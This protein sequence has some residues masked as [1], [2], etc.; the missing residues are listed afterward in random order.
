MK[1]YT[2]THT[3]NKFRHALLSDAT[4]MPPTFS[5]IWGLGTSSN[6]PPHPLTKIW[7]SSLCPCQGNLR[8][9]GTFVLHLQI[10][11]VR[12]EL[13]NGQLSSFAICI[14]WHVKSS[15]AHS[16]LISEQSHHQTF[17]S[18]ITGE[19]RPYLSDR[20][21]WPR[22]P[23]GW[24]RPSSVT[25]KSTMLRTPPNLSTV[26][27]NYFQIPQIIDNNVCSVCQCLYIPGKSSVL[28]AL[29]Y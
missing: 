13:V 29:N 20:P 8:I 3:I 15:G 11:S 1:P 6:Q 17:S 27:S 26:W 2:P 23:V 4:Q 18:F 24:G 16:I 19:E 28:C 12:L 22:N 14:L 21:S 25:H 10:F 5:Y 7:E 9:E